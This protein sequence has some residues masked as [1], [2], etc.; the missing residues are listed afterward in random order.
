MATIEIADVTTGYTDG[1]G[2]FDTLMQA[3]NSHLK[4]EYE[5][6]RIKGSDYST[7]YLSSMQ[8]VLQQAITFI[9]QKQ[10][11]AIEADI[12]EA[13]ILKTTAEIALL[14]A[15]KATEQAQILD[16]VDGNPV[17]GL[18]GKQ[19]S[20]YEKQADGFDRDAEVKALKILVDLYSVAKSS[21][22]D[23]I[24][25]FRWFGTGSSYTDELEAA[26]NNAVVNAGLSQIFTT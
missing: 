17:I 6:G 24:T 9:L 2:V 1:D 16:T 8:S 22:P 20:L 4:Q 12:A 15:K 21:D 5:E 13:N 7:V 18:V 25:D 14:E 23:S 10:K 26:I 3:V 19:K 11:A